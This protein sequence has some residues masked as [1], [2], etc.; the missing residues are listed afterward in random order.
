MT[1][2]ASIFSYFL[3]AGLVVKSVM[4]VLLI[5]SVFSW[6]Y[7]LQRIVYIRQVNRDSQR[8]ERAFWSG[9]DLNALYNDAVL[10]QSD[11]SEQIFHAGYKEYMRFSKQPNALV[12]QVIDNASRSM[13][14]AQTKA[15]DK[16]ETSLPF[17]AIVGSTSPYIG[18]FGT[19]WGIMVSFTALSN[20]SQATLNMVAPGIAEA[21]VA[22]AL[23]LFAAIPANIAYNR[24]ITDIGR[25]NSRFDA[26]REEFVNVL[27]R[28]SI[29]ST[30]MGVTGTQQTDTVEV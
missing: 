29:P 13:R 21:L 20:A 6:A 7:I 19:V 25:L 10:E 22:T 1:V 24:F 5:A 16:L 2:D 12:S 30:T 23:G 17:L 28:H 15:L 4:A 8:F 14:V 27:T 3:Q 26:F 9:E 11:G 18:L